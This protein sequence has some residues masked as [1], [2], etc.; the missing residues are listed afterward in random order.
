M[1]QFVF[2]DEFGNTGAHLLGTDQPLLV[3]AFVVVNSSS[4]AKIADELQSLYSKEG[5]APGELKS[6]R[7][8]ASSRGRKRYEAI[9][10]SVCRQ[11]ARVL[12]SIVE[13]RYQ[14]CA[15]IAETFLDP[16]LHDDAPPEMKE[17]AFRQKF[18]DACYDAID[19]RRLVE[20]LEAVRADN[21]PAIVAVG[22]RFSATLRLHPDDFVSYAAN[23]M[24]ARTESVF[25]YSQRRNGLPRNS[26]IP[27]SQYAAFYPGLQCVDAHL[28][29]IAATAVLVRDEDAH[30]GE[31]LD[32]AL[33]RGKDLDLL[34]GAR[35]YGALQLNRIQSYRSASSEQELGIQIA[36]LAA[37]VFGRA[38]RAC[39]LAN[40]IAPATQK[41]VDA[42]RGTID[43]P[44]AHYVM[45][46]DA[47]LPH[48]AA[49][50]FGS[51]YRRMC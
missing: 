51:D 24:E 30:F 31:P 36:D 18:S 22:K 32:I 27:A 41:I 28:D 44:G 33:E 7:L 23:R 43:F 3:Y 12:L 5:I 42:W 37:G 17:R 26:H 40:Q 46:S 45:V 49:A 6:A 19:D 1:Q 8:I 48:V 35:D 10:E 38:A 50:I 47:R 14:A 9:G 20:F 39:A 4:L 13:K 25:R 15:M 2:C 16:F 11:G 21:A 34:S 29:R